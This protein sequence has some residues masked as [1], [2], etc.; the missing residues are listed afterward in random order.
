MLFPAVAARAEKIGDIEI[1][2]QPLPNADIRSGRENGISHGYVEYRVQLKNSSAKDHTVELSYPAARGS[3]ARF[4]VVASRT[5]QVLAGQ[6]AS[7][8]LFEPA[9][10]GESGSMRVR[11]DGVKEAREIPVDSLR[12]GLG[13]YGYEYGPAARFAV[14]LSRGVPQEFRDRASPAAKKPE[15]EA[16]GPE[17]GPPGYR[18]PGYGV[19]E[20]GSAGPAFLR[21]DVPVSQWSP[22]WL[23]YSCYDAILL[24]EQEAEEM[25]APAQAA[26]RR[27]LECGGALLVHGRKVPGVFSRGGVSDGQG[28]HYVG[29][30]R[31]AASSDEGELGWDKAHR[32]LAAKSLEIYRPLHRPNDPHGLLVGE[33]TV[34]VR[35]LFF[36]VLL[37]A[38]AIGPVNVW[39]L[40]K[41]RKRIW[42]WWNVPAISLL[43]CLAVFCYAMLSEGWTS[44]G[45]TASFTFLDER[46]HRATTIG[47]VSLYCP[48]TPGGL[49]FSADTDLALLTRE[50]PYSRY[51]PYRE[52]EGGPQSVDWTTDQHLTSGWVT[53]RVPAYFQI[54]KNEDRRERLTVG[55]KADGSVTV[56]NAL[57]ADIRRVFLADASGRVF[58]G[59]D[60]PA[61]AERT[62][63]TASGGWR[64]SAG[65]QAELRQLLT[66]AE[67]LSTF[68][69]WNSGTNLAPILSPGGYVAFLSKSPF[70]D[71][72][73]SRANCE[74]SVAIVCGISEGPGDGR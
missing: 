57:G 5:V 11:V 49:H 74:H 67:W 73:L 46:C 53:A 56:V 3:V 26:V 10:G 36:L 44:R 32:W 48:L 72:P 66:R 23:G 68:R 37:F 62:L 8:S 29:L 34:P 7:V 20:Y 24:T 35:G 21:S 42:L 59:G 17:Y 31:A 1:I 63:S 33:A 69:D 16:P 43:T 30:G 70:V 45:K 13:R 64:L 39:L 52:T 50:R 51:S 6:E 15:P 40:S 28:G 22:T 14:L 41:Y 58:E 9:S 60:I 54:R 2:V 19:A 71:S 4:G 55:K 61:G 27:Y 38:V 65:A 18:P 47:Y 12:G 25:P